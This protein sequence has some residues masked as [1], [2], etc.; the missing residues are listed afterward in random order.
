MLARPTGPG[1]PTFAGGDRIVVSCDR[2]HRR[3]LGIL[4]A[5]PALCLAV[6][7][8]SILAAPAAHL[9]GSVVGDGGRPVAGATVQVVRVAAEPPCQTTTAADGTFSLSCAANGLHVVRAS[10]GDLR[11]WEIEDVELEPGRE[12]YLNFMLLP[13][14]A[15]APADALA[16]GPTEAAG[17]WSR[18]LPNPVLGSWQGTAITL[19]MLAIGVAVVSF[20]LGAATMMSLGRRFGIEKRRLSADEVGDLVLNPHMP[21]AGERVTPA[22]V[23][24]ARG[25]SVTVT[26]GADEIADAFA[27][28]RYGTVLVA[29]VIAPGLFALFSMAL[30]LAMLIGQETYLLCL[31]L[32]VPAGFLLTAVA[33]GI[34]AAGR[35]RGTD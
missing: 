11:P 24:G 14:T 15:T 35:N 9:T 27:A 26:Y 29:L 8:A 34:Q 12:I 22:L 17:F 31:A 2:M 7:A 28:R 19:R 32:I 21:A 23:V 3:T 6:S 30:A 16:A 33:I 5:L 25:A 1:S 18:P 13:V 10:F 20:L 4:L